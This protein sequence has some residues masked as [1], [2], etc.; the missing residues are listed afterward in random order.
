MPIDNIISICGSFIHTIHIT[1]HEYQ[2]K[3]QVFLPERIDLYVGIVLLDLW[4]AVS[5][6]WVTLQ[7]QESRP[8]EMRSG[9]MI[10]SQVC[11]TWQKEHQ[12]LHYFPGHSLSP[13]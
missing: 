5:P 6:N 1:L 8:P 12:Y 9:F 2:Y 11:L 10:A 4:Y 3:I 7:W 13:G